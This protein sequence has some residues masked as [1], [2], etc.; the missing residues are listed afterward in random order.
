MKEPKQ[1]SKE[2]PQWK[3]QA[4]RSQLHTWGRSGSFSMG[5]LP[6]TKPIPKISLPKLKFLEEDK[7]G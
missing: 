4:R 1:W 7:D 5:G 3:T 6:R 2:N